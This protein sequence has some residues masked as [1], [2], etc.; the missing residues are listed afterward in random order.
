[1]SGVKD[2][3]VDLQRHRL[4]LEGKV[5][6]LQ[7]DLAHWQT[8]DAEYEAL[9]EEVDELINPDSASLNRIKESFGG[10]LLTQREIEEIFGGRNL[11]S[12][13]QVQGVLD[14][15]IDYVAQNIKTLG[16]QLEAAENKYAAATIISQPDATDEEGQPI[17]EIIEELDD[18]GNVLNHRLNKPGDSIPQ[19][20]EALEKAGVKDLTGSDSEATQKPPQT[21]QS[22]DTLA[23]KPS[24]NSPSP[25]T[26]ESK[27]AQEELKPTSPAPKGITFTPDTKTED[28]PRPQ[29][30][31]NAKRVEAI[32]KEAKEQE[33]TSVDKPMIPEDEDEDDAEMRR[34]MLAYSMS[35]V[36][37][38]VAEL[39]LMEGD[40]DEEDY[41]FDY[42]DEGFE[43][44]DDDEDKYGRHTG[45]VITDGYRQRMLEL[46]KKLGVKSRFT[47][48]EEAK[49]AARQA[50]Q[51]EE[52]EA[53]S[54][55]ERIGR[56]VVRPNSETTP[57]SAASSSK[58]AP[59][60]SNLKEKQ[61]AK[62]SSKKG[63]RFA[64]SLDIAPDD[65][66]VT[67]P[68]DEVQEKEE[69]LVEPLSDIVERSGP[70]KA[71][72]TT[73]NRKPS[74]FKKSR[75]EAAS[76]PR[77]PV[78]PLDVPARFLDQDRPIA[79]T[80]PKGTTIADI[81]V[82]R[83]TPVAARPPGEFDEDMIHEEV[84][85]EYQRLR[86]KFIHRDGGFLK[87]DESPIRPLDDDEDSKE[88]VSRF[89]AARLSKH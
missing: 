5:K 68:V 38:V 30:S 67:R 43:D 73:S 86:K 1:M 10:E 89:K 18:D 32:M 28:G 65:A 11:R 16:K 34:Q 80:G 7:K 69:P 81:L 47:T 61:P 45:S 66:P 82:E 39:E 59:T 84:A 51:E 49:E 23:N 76:D 33:T 42:S 52:G 25:I 8:W 37:A 71:V 55:D 74:R 83:E 36:G 2:S 17:T 21:A 3:F 72:E 85:G 27:K 57:S 12:R 29:V 53:S 46:E 14:R 13:D 9:K 50:K 78:G 24:H 64:P 15:R 19:I 22:Q 77:L 20:Q 56:I 48:S 6:K 60:K 88:P 62:A 75:G 31:R 44:G 40:T 79:P 26:S 58:L 87:E 41:D 35:E 54:D 70:T 4:Q 63:V